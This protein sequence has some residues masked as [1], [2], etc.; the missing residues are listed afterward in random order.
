MFEEYFLPVRRWSPIS[1]DLWH[2]W[3]MFLM[4]CCYSFRFSQYYGVTT[5]WIFFFVVFIWLEVLALSDSTPPTDSLVI[6]HEATTHSPSIVTPYVCL[7]VVPGVPRTRMKFQ[8]VSFFIHTYG[9]NNIW[10]SNSQYCKNKYVSFPFFLHGKSSAVTSRCRK[11]SIDFHRTVL[12]SIRN[13]LYSGRF[14]EPIIET[15]PIISCI[16]FFLCHSYIV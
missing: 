10:K 12:H 4:L 16:V 11:Q 1:H 13:P 7:Y 2:Q 5:F 9:I 15:S 8:I 14:V 6:P 3:W